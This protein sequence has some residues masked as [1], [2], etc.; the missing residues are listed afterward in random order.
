[1]PYGAPHLDVIQTI[2]RRKEIM[3]DD[4]SLINVEIS[5]DERDIIMRLF[6]QQI[7]QHGG[8]NDSEALKIVID[9][10]THIVYATLRFTKAEAEVALLDVLKKEG[11]HINYSTGELPKRYA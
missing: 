7:R 5:F 8:I 4:K 10:T 2:Y 9:Q 11:E 6:H 3:T 1:M